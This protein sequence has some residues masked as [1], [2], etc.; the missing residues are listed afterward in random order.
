MSVHSIHSSTNQRQVGRG[1]E[2]RGGSLRRWNQHF[3]PNFQPQLCFDQL[4]WPWASHFPLAF[5]FCKMSR[6]DWIVLDQGLANCGL[7]TKS[8]P[9]L[10]FVNKVLLQ[11]SMLIF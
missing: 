11:Q 4:V 1:H 2:V 6:E 5:P 9:Q 10:V 8:G 3:N 7:R